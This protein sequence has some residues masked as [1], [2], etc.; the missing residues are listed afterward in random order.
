MDPKTTRVK[1]NSQVQT[2]A[3]PYTLSD[4]A[5]IEMDS[6]DAPVFDLTPE[7]QKT[8]LAETIMEALNAFEFRPVLLAEDFQTAKDASKAFSDMTID[9]DTFTAA[10]EAFNKACRGLFFTLDTMINSSSRV[11]A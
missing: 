6:D 3:R 9:H 8:L 7:A 1:R 10:Q 11:K 5:L 2:E 4:V